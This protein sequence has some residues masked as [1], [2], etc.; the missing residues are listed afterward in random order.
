[1]PAETTTDTA[2]LTAVKTCGDD[3][4]DLNLAEKR[5]LDLH[6]EER[7]EQ[8]IGPLCVNPDLTSIARARSRDMLDRDYFDHT[9][10]EGETVTDQPKRM[11]YASY[12]VGE[13]ISR[14]TA[15]SGSQIPENNF[16]SFMQ[17]PG[18]HK[19]NTL[20]KEFDEVG[21]VA[22]LEGTY[23]PYDDSVVYTVVF[24]ASSRD[25]NCKR[26]ARR[27]QGTWLTYLSSTRRRP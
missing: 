11:G 12:L 18:H 17:S 26:R 15:G 22:A 13:N 7:R 14:G 5:M 1:M 6:N 21:V 20:R 9:T 4:T 24:A 25:A 8:G 3:L 16:R 2:T 19:A 23:G 27:R 10:P